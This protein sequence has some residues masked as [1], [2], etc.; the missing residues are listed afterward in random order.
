MLLVD[1][2]ASVERSVDRPCRLDLCI[3]CISK[4]VVVQKFCER[5]MFIQL[6]LGEEDASVGEHINVVRI[7]RLQQAFDLSRAYVLT[8]PAKDHGM[9]N[10]KTYLL[11]CTVGDL[12]T[13]QK[14]F[15]EARD[16]SLLQERWH[17]LQCG[18]DDAKAH[19]LSWTTVRVTGCCLST[20]AHPFLITIWHVIL[21]HVY[22]FICNP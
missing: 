10:P 9:R 20:S 15:H 11:A 3:G 12:T 14:N 7:V 22:F 4:D 6:S 1:E 2:P 17:Q 21:F 19:A 16:M 8:Q 13:V 5:G 18:R